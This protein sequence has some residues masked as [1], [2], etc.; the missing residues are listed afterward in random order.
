M[1]NTTTTAWFTTTDMMKPGKAHATKECADKTATA[2]W[3]R[4]ADWC[5]ENTDH[6]PTGEVHE[7]EVSPWAARCKRCN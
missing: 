7:K 4:M 3:N 5:K 2:T 1:N 6:T